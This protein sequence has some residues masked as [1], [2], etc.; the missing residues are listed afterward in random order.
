MLTEMNFL[1]VLPN[2][3]W[4]VMSSYG[5]SSKTVSASPIEKLLAEVLTVAIIEPSRSLK[6]AA[7][8]YE[9]TA[10]LTSDS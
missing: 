1:H 8:T 2:V 10:W 7:V 9:C 6:S 5:T 3:P 4:R